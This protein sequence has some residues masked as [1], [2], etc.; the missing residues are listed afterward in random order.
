ML[1]GVGDRSGGGVVARAL[2]L[3]FRYAHTTAHAV[4]G[5][6]GAGQPRDGL[7]LYQSPPLVCIPGLCGNHVLAA[8]LPPFPPALLPDNGAC[9]F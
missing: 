9:F 7:S 1:V 6:G 8:P 4:E 5:G 2:L 3:S